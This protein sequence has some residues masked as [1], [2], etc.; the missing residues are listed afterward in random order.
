[1]FLQAKNAFYQLITVLFHAL[2]NLISDIMKKLKKLFLKR[3][4]LSHAKYLNY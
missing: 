1:M 3:A 4:I 2:K